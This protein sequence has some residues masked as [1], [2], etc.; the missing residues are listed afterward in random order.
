[1][2]FKLYI[3]QETCIY[4]KISWTT[5]KS[6]RMKFIRNFQRD[7]IKLRMS[8]KWKRWWKLSL[9]ID[10]CSNF[11]ISQIPKSSCLNK[12]ILSKSWCFSFHWSDWCSVSFLSFRE[13]YWRSLSLLLLLF[14]LSKREL[15]LL[16]DQVWKLRLMMFAAP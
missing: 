10:I 4:L 6:K 2:S 3:W 7:I 8:Q 5:P 13:I 12:I 15:K 16:K 11:S 9:L 1:M 14:I